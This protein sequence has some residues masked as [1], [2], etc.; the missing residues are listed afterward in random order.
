LPKDFGL[1]DG[2]KDL[3]LY[4]P[5]GQ[6]RR[7]KFLICLGLILPCHFFFISSSLHNSQPS[8]LSTTKATKNQHFKRKPTPSTASQLPTLVG[9]RGGT[10]M[11]PEKVLAE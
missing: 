10:S 3:H 2:P 4:I 11:A 6:S 1:C 8:P 5:I 7:E 9:A